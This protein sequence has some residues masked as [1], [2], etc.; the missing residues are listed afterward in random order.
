MLGRVSLKA[1]TYTNHLSISSFPFKPSAGECR[2]T[3]LKGT[4]MQGLAA[5]TVFQAGKSPIRCTVQ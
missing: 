5:I 2:C 1:P 3:L 4:K